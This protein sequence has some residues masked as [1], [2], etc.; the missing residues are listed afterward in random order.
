VLEGAACDLSLELPL[1][2][3]PVADD[4]GFGD[5]EVDPSRR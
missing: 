5:R 1:S 4:E 2:L 3:V